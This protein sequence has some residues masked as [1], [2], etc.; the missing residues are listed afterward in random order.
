MRRFILLS[1]ILF[2]F[3]SM[4]T[5]E[6]VTVGTLHMMAQNQT[7]ELDDIVV[8]GHQTDGDD[9]DY[10]PDDLWNQGMNIGSDGSGEN[11]GENEG[12]NWDD[13]SSY[14]GNDNSN[15]NSSFCDNRYYPENNEVDICCKGWGNYLPYSW[16]KQ[17]LPMECFILT[18]EYVS[19]FYKC[20]LTHNYE[21]DREEFA[22]DYISLYGYDP[23]L[24]GV[25]SKI[26]YAFMEHEGFRF[27]KISKDD[28]IDCIN[29]NNPVMACVENGTH[30]VLIIG[31]LDTNTYKAANPATGKIEKWNK[32]VF[33]GCMSIEGYRLYDN[34]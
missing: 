1:A 6:K 10:D 5:G 29:R 13:E 23:S 14:I 9:D 20:S 11:S 33:S 17:I 32:R 28:I 26:A 22:M 31:Y 21:Y 2:Q 12:T 30:E 34:K 19:N 27:S 25:H 18:M 3:L 24:E 16:E 4:L 15:N 7:C 8:I